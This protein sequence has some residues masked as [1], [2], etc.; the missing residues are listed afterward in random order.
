MASGHHDQ[1]LARPVLGFQLHNLAQRPYDGHG[2]VVSRNNVP[3]ATVGQVQGQ[4]TL[5]G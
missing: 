2:L 4:A 5:D 1:R 3:G